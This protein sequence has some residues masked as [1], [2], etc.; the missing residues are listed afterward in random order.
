VIRRGALV[1]LAALAG[2]CSSGAAT[3]TVTAADYRFDNLPA[4]VKAGTKLNLRNASATELHEM[5][6]V[7]LRDGE[8]RPAGA[9]A[10]LP[11]SEFDALLTG[12]T[13]T[14]L[15]RPPGNADLIHAL[16][17]GRLNEKGRYLVVCTIPRGV[18][19]AAFLAA[20]RGPKDAPTVTGGPPHYTLGMYGEIRV[21]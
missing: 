17:D 1:A 11:G 13:V 6:V 16:G 12:A 5:L 18:D 19:P 10:T 8:Q 9:L 4:V 7:K 14:V 3:R 2:A 21:Q 15:L 20:T